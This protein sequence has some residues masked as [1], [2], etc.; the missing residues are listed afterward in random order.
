MEAAKAEAS[1][2]GERVPLPSRYTETMKVWA[3]TDGKTL[4]AELSTEPVQLE[5]PDK[6]GKKSWQPVD[7][8]IEIKPDG[9]LTPKLVKTPLTFGGEGTHTLV[10]AKD[11]D[12]TVALGW[13][14]KLPKP[15]VDG[16]RITYRDAVAKGADLVLTA[17][18]NGFAQN[19]VLRTRPQAPIKISLPVTLPKGSS[20]GK[21]ADGKPQ[22]RSA[23]G[24]AESAP[25]ATQ[26]VDAKAAEAPDQ[27]KVG[28]VDTSVTT[29]ASGKSSLVLT[30]DAAF[31]ADPSVTYPVIVPMS[32]E[33]IGAG[34]SSDTFVSSVQYPNSATLST[35][36]RAGKSA[37]GELWRTY[38]RYVINGTDLDYATINDADLRLWNYHA[39]GCGTTVG[40]GIVARRLTSAYDYSTLTWANQPSSTGTNAVV[41]TGGYSATLAGCSG[42]GEL[43]YS[44]QDIVQQWADGTSDY[45][46]MI[47]AATEGAAGANWR[48]YRSDQYTGSDGRGPVLFINYVPARTGVVTYE[49]DGLPDTAI[50]TYSELIEDQVATGDSPETPTV[51]LEE[52]VARLEQSTETFSIDPEVMETVP[53][54]PEEEPSPDVTPPE[55]T[56]TD[57]ANGATGVPTDAR[58]TV[59]LSEPVTGAQLAVKDNAGNAVAGTTSMD[60]ENVT[61]FFTPASSWAAE[62]TFAASVTGGQD[63]AGNPLPAHSWSFTTGTGSGTPTDTTPPSVASTDPAPGTTGVAVG[64]QITVSFSEPV[65]N[66][67]VELT[68]A[69]GTVISG[70][71]TMDDASTTLTFAPGQSLA[72]ATAYTVEASGATDAAGN[73]MAAHS[74]SFT[75]A[76]ATSGTTI[77][78]NPSFESGLDPWYAW[79][80]EDDVSSSTEQAH[81]GSASAKLVAGECCTAIAQDVEASEGTYQLSGWIRAE[82][83]AD[84]WYGVDWY[85]AD[86]NLLESA[87]D[88]TEPSVGTWSPLTD[89]TV[90]APAGTAY[91]IMM[92]EADFLDDAS[93]YTVYLD[94]L[95]MTQK[96]D[97]ASL[98]T[99]GRRDGQAPKLIKELREKIAQQGKS[100]REVVATADDAPVQT[101]APAGF[102]GYGNDGRHMKFADCWAEPKS[103]SKK[104]YPHGWTKNAY[105]WCSV[106]TIGKARWIE[107]R[108]PCPCAP[109]AKYKTIDKVEFQLSV[110][111]HTFAGGKKDSPNAEI[112]VANGSINSRTMRFWTYIDHIKIVKDDSAHRYKLPLWTEE[113]TI[114]VNLS[115]GGAPKTADSC[116]RTHGDGQTKTIAAWRPDAAKQ[117]YFE[118]VSDKA[119]SGGG[120]HQLSTCRV[121]PVVWV[122][123]GFVN[124]KMVDEI[125][126]CDTSDELKTYYGG[127]VF[128]AHTPTYVMPLMKTKNVNNPSGLDESAVMIYQ[129]LRPDLTKSTFPKYADKVPIGTRDSEKPLHRS[130]S[131]TRD[132]RNRNVSLRFCSEMLAQ[133][134]EPKPAQHDCDEYPF[135]ATHEG[136]GSDGKGGLDDP[137][138][139]RI[140][141]RNVVVDYVWYQDN[142]SVGSRAEK[143]WQIFR[144]L[145]SAPNGSDLPHPYTAFWVDTSR[146]G[147][148]G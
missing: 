123:E 77:N 138:G 13:G 132:T 5:V 106:R 110:I 114:G 44:I 139:K 102:V 134:G 136:S 68:D 88:Y 130:S 73:T 23:Q 38:L 96:T 33:W 11:K 27:G 54:E 58:L 50:P 37:D 89:V 9:T 12:G 121:T 124:T 85:D 112:D 41:N 15:V 52:A 57:P 120:V 98:R 95:R 87:Y 43:Y 146:W 47:R 113:D 40:V 36:L 129:M 147:N 69:A 24:A 108:V 74:W 55:V 59:L 135:A 90:T 45:G 81:D 79:W 92:A 1:K 115:V 111:G 66:A 2:T 141:N 86:W 49:R 64:T 67:Q 148:V 14:R 20:Y 105:N 17:R 28:N 82:N 4:H 84:V 127:C 10:T 34:D 145:G 26:A 46:L 137:K 142:R 83:T 72:Y 107:T 51:S 7:T 91:A 143:F 61:M 144:V 109:D 48:Q 117:S 62:T 8:T 53:D 76:A 29:D 75:T 80:A 70:S 18:P 116:K 94:D 3:N 63:T 30:P 133:L 6:D 125:I 131:G 93:S 60:A 99:A 39:N 128:V 22:L 42:S 119:H 25:L 100:G 103:R 140:T 31:L 101:A 65:T 97:V 19:V 118:F 35:W 71:A 78:A 126:R 104:T 21:A 16:N 122:R 56:G 32:S